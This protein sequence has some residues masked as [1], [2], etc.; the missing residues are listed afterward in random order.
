MKISNETKIGVLAVVA[1][2]ALILGFNFLKGNSLFQ[3]TKKLY[4]VFDNVEG[5]EVSNAVQING[6]QIGNIT[7]INESDKDLSQGVVV[8]ISLKK[9]VHIPDNSVASINSGL[10]SSASIVIDRG[11]SD[12]FLDNGD[13]I[14]TKRKINL[15]SQV[16][17]SV[18]PVILKLGGTLTSLDSLIE[19]IGTMFDPRLKNNFSSIITNL[20]ASSAELQKLLNAQSGAL[21]QSLR[22]VNEFTGNLAKNNDHVT[23]TLENV[24]KT[25]ANLAA[26][27][28]PETVQSLQSTMNELKNVLDKV[29]STNGSMGM[30]LNDKRL[31]N[32]LEA[33]TRSLNT[34]L[35]DFRVHP[36]RYV[37]ISVFGKK[38]K[39]GP[40]M[41][42]IIDSTSTSKPVNK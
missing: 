27:K 29:N 19:V 8:T 31:Y 5:L 13:T 6:L 20:A 32:N 2:A 1:L 25:T 36:K 15:F 24:D 28:I 14:E 23:H 30:L 42:P 11:S 41:S 34:L 4:A 9:D 39:T 37:N 26:A 22:N 16:Q 10:I 35:D 40:L 18:N 3:H 38:D 21:A 12:K 7:S 33:S 17:S